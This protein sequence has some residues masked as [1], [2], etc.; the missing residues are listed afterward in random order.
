MARGVDA[1]ALPREGRA[2]GFTQPADVWNN[3]DVA[4][5]VDTG[6]V[7]ALVAE[8]G[9]AVDRVALEAA[10]Q[11]QAIHGGCL[12]TLLLEAGLVDEASLT[13]ALAT[14]S[15]TEP[16][17]RRH[18][19]YPNQ[20]ATTRLPRR[21]AITMGLM[22]LFV[23]DTDALH[24]GCTSPLDRDLIGE[25]AGL[26]H[27]RIV[28]H[29]VSEVRLRQGL[30]AAYNHPV[31]ERFVALLRRLDARLDEPAA[32]ATGGDAGDA[33]EERVT[34]DVAE[35]LAHL[36]A[37]DSRDG[38]TRVVLAFAR[39]FLPFAA[40]IGVRDGHAVGW[41]RQGLSEGLLFGQPLPIPK[42]SFLAGA[43]DAASPSLVSPE[44]NDDNDAVFGWLGR[45]R[46]KTVLTVPIVIARRPIGA[47]I[48]D[49]GPRQRAPSEVAEL[50]AFASRLG[51]A[52][53]ALLRQRHT[54]S[55]ALPAPPPLSLMSGA[56][57]PVL[58]VDAASWF[59][60]DVLPAP[61]P[62]AVMPPVA[63]ARSMPAVDLAVDR[64]E[65]SSTE[66]ARIFPL[67][68]ASAPAAWRGALEATVEQGLQ[69]GTVDDEHEWEAV[70]YEPYPVTEKK[71]SPTTQKTAPKTTAAASPTT[72]T[73]TAAA[74]AEVPAS[75]SS[76]TRPPDSGLDLPALSTQVLHD[77]YD[78]A[79]D[80]DTNAPPVDAEAPPPP[81][82]TLSHA[83]VVDLLFADDTDVVDRAT[84]ELVHRGRA[85]VPALEARFPGRLR[86][87]PFDP[88]ENVRHASRLGPLVDVLAR[89]GSDGLEAAVVYIESRYPAHRFAAVLLFALTPN[90]RAVDL[91]RNRLYDAEPRI[92]RLATEALLPFLA[93]PRFE[94]LLVH[95]RDRAQGTTRSSPLEARR[96]ATELLGEF[97]D[98]SAVPLLL[99]LLSSPDLQEVAARALRAI[100]LVDFGTRA[101]GWEKWWSKARKRSR[102]DWLID[103]LGS[104][105]LELRSSAWRELTS[106]VGDDFG[107]RPDADRRVRQR[108]LAVWQQW[109]NDEQH[110]QP[111][112]PPPRGPT[113][114]DSTQKGV[115]KAVSTP[116]PPTSTSSAS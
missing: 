3:T 17:D 37:K 83:E 15:Q 69:G 116:A 52:F 105:E 99:G 103:G 94:G 110:H 31:D 19:T 112:E 92:Q 35:A 7:K 18:F 73:T 4:A 98:V 78:A 14:A 12:D 66:T 21:M 22:P 89:L 91:L 36:A 84:R 108:A 64:P 24:L 115:D 26:I 2:V 70:V 34:W 23:D 75:L 27:Q 85:A 5:R 43:L 63:D 111:A 81:L 47:L 71:R 87:D 50:T 28:A 82:P 79:R 10:V 101:K 13:R 1:S 48:G 49:G 104:E 46:P 45:R 102:I 62:L 11:Q 6:L 80:E 88:G 109:W 90:V 56:Q 51:P 96:R 100:T 55:S 77:L 41:M 44:A 9:A 60:A 106:L 40:V 72:T 59:D 8:A 33:G 30:Q 76:T 67:P 95:L 61:P 16:V 65:A 39:R 32:P 97:R 29:V 25:V 57:P 38:I 74:E 107:Y 113:N 54:T 20:Q 53:E 58:S 86:V 93:H 68:D 42:K 114:P